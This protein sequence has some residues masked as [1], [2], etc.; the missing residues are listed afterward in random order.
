MGS[1]TATIQAGACGFVVEAVASTGVARRGGAEKA[2]A[3]AH[4]LLAYYAGSSAVGTL[5]GVVLARAGWSGV[6]GMVA[7]LLGAALA[8]AAALGRTS[9][10]GREEAAT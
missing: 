8:V 1:A 7:A 9:E 2:A 10:S 5:G 4:Y 3:S 6:V